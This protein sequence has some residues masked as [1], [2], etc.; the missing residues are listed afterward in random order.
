METGDII[1]TTSVYIEVVPGRNE[2]YELVVVLPC[3][4]N[5]YLDAIKTISVGL[6]SYNPIVNGAFFWLTTDDVMYKAKPQYGG[7]EDGAQGFSGW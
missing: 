5:S 7:P 6:G 1:V 4:K 3:F 2:R